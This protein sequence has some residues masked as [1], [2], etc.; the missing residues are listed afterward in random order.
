MLSSNTKAPKDACLFEYYVFHRGS[1]RQ[2]LVEVISN[3]C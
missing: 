2:K 3:L 1:A